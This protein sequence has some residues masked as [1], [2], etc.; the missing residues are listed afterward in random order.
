M[1]EET[2]LR[3]RICLSNVLSTDV[4]SYTSL[5]PL[6]CY[7]V[8]LHTQ[9]PVDEHGIFLIY[10]SY[11][12][13]LLNVVLVGLHYIRNLS[14][15][16]LFCHICI[17]PRQ[18]TEDYQVHLQPHVSSLSFHLNFSLYAVLLRNLLP[19]FCSRTALMSLYCRRINAEIFIIRIF[20]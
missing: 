13:F 2:G 16:L 5:L 17:V 20:L 8:L 10:H 12:R 7:Y 14:F 11:E 9:L 6:N 3:R 19:P 18:Y 15:F 1:V 4:M